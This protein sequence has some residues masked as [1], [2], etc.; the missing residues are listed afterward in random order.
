[1]YA[2]ALS[3]MYFVLSEAIGPDGH[4][5]FRYLLLLLLSLWT[6]AFVIFIVPLTALHA[7]KVGKR[8]IVTGYFTDYRVL[9]G[10]HGKPTLLASSISTGPLQTVWSIAT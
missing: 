6:L 8:P 1:M 3:Q 7:W 5:K 4:F 10:Y 9:P 2:G